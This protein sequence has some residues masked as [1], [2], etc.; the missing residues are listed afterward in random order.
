MS[1]AKWKEAHPDIVFSDDALKPMVPFPSLAINDYVHYLESR[2][3]GED[4]R[5]FVKD[6]AR[7]LAWTYDNWSKAQRDNDGVRLMDDI[8]R[9]IPKGEPFSDFLLRFISDYRAANNLNW[10][11]PYD[12]KAWEVAM[13]Q[14]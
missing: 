9:N 2:G 4:V 8:V 6:V 12:Q 3:L 1:V 11:N 13:R 5:S 10:A 7:E 14:P